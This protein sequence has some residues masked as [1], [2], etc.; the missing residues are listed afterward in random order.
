MRWLMLVLLLGCGAPTGPS[1]I[2]W[3]TG[4]LDD[5]GVGFATIETED[6]ERIG[7][8]DTLPLV[9]CYVAPDELDNE[10]V[11]IAANY[12]FFGGVCELVW[13]TD[14]RWTVHI[15]N[16]LPNWWFRVVAVY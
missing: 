6:G 16:S 12:R 14:Q 15:F 4:Q 13:T 9:T 8:P 7:F 11:V 5:F 2:V 1:D 3:I 10:W